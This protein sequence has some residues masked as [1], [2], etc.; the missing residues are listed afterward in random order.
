MQIYKSR[1]PKI[2][3]NKLPSAFFLGKKIE[4]NIKY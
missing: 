2:N 1:P 3:N 4:E